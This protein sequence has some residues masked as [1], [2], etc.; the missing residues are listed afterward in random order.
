MISE[1]RKSHCFQVSVQTARTDGRRLYPA[2]PDYGNGIYR[3]RIVLAR[4]STR[5]EARLE[6]SNHAFS[7]TLVHDGQHV[8]G[9]DGRALRYPLSTCPQ[10][11]TRLQ[12][13]VGLPRCSRIMPC[14]PPCGI[15]PMEKQRPVMQSGLTLFAIPATVPGVPHYSAELQCISPAPLDEPAFPFLDTA[16][17]QRAP[18]VRRVLLPPDGI[19]A[20]PFFLSQRLFDHF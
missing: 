12:K 5:V 9:V 20:A 4:R 16:C 10:A 19:S 11:M 6:D 7:L 8:T 15:K 18:R 14:S 2:N 13:F 17:G 1:S 3:R